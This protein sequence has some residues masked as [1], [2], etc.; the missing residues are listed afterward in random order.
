MDMT[1]QTE[2]GL[3]TGARVEVTMTLEVPI[4]VLWDRVSDVTQI[5]RFSPECFEAKMTDAHHFVGRNRFLEGH[6]SEA[7]G[8]VT[9]RK[10]PTTFAWTMLDDTGDN[11]SFW[12]YDLS[13]GVEPGT[14]V[15][16]HSFE[17]GPG[18]TGLRVIA[19][20][21]S[22]VIPVRLGRLAQNMSATLLAMGR[23]TSGK[24][25]RA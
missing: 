15:V 3:L 11:G 25:E 24:G 18:N 2:H 6:V 4:N 9:E 5:G 22:A 14:S 13:P 1:I 7:L 12:R 19:V 8:I 16:R 23:S 21:D 10:A 20:T 17:H